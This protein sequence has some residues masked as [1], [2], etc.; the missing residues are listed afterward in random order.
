[1]KRFTDTKKWQGDWFQ[2]LKSD[3]KVIWMYLVDSCNNAGV[4]SPNIGMLEYCTGVKFNPDRFKEAFKEKVRI[5]PCGKWFIPSFIEFQQGCKIQD[6][7]EKNNAHKQILRLLEL[8]DYEKSSTWEP[9][10]GGPKEA[11]YSIVKYSIYKKEKDSDVNK[12]IREEIINYFNL[13]AGTNYRSNSKETVKLI[14]ARLKDGFTL[15]DFKTVIDVKC[16][17]WL[18][19]PEM[20]SYLRPTTLFGSKFE[21]YLNEKITANLV[22]NE[23]IDKM[24]LKLMEDGEKERERIMNEPDY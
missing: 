4:I 8:I 2:P 20:G 23:D 10:M 17:S 9:P 1:M 6:L 3:D 24:V 15:D 14:D 22:T 5:L 7:S 19:S 18:K 16:K 12:N 11:Q 21:S 13:K